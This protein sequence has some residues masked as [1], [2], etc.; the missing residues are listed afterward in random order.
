MYNR[1][2]KAT[3]AALT[4]VAATTVIGT[5]PSG[6][7]SIGVEGCTP[8]YWKNHTENWLET[9]TKAIPTNALVTGIF[10]PGAGTRPNLSG[11]TLLQA[12]QGGGGSGVDG[13]TLILA[14]AATAAYLNAAHEDLG[15]PWRR[16]TTGLDARPALVPTVSKAFE[17][18]DR[19]TMLSL[20][21]RLD[22][23]N[24][25]GCPLS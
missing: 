1:L 20:A 2:K 3:C 25:L 18:G 21:Q 22:A 15:Y 7:T 19:T 4:V 6:A 16:K 24:N 17:S 9:S 11:L 8:G 5:A 14:R 13:A 23:D 10:A 12:L